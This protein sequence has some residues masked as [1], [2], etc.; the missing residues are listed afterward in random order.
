MDIKA[1][2]IDRRKQRTRR[3]LR[4]AL[5]ELIVEKG[6]EHTSIQ[7]ITD[8]ADVSRATFYLHYTGGK[9]E[10]LNSSIREMYDELATAYQS[11]SLQE[12][13]ETGSS[14]TLIN[15]ADY[16]HVAD[17]ADFYRAMLS[18]KGAPFFISTV[19]SY[20]ANVCEEMLIEAEQ[21]SG[22]KPVVPVEMMAHALAGLEIGVVMWWLQSGM[23]HSPE[24]MAKM[25]YYLAAFGMWQTLGLAVPAPD[26]KLQ[27]APNDT[28]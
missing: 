18:E 3:M 15:P 13:L 27:A 14:E 4:Q 21:H 10:L 8:R 20:L 22:Q 6:Y 12:V 11:F 25:H 19:H 7:D 17:H 5:L 9:E 24:Q 1:P 23:H 2:K 26:F 28:Q 16:Q